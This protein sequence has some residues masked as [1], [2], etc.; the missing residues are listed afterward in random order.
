MDASEFIPMVERMGLQ[1]QTPLLTSQPTTQIFKQ[2]FLQVH[3]QT[4]I[5]FAVLR[6]RSAAR[7]S[8]WQALHLSL[9]FSKLLD[10]S[11]A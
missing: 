6:M 8:A 10:A 3:L 2:L 7:Y 5:D 1:M 11:P 9:T 4:A